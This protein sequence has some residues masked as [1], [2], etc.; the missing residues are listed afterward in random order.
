[1][2]CHP[3]RISYSIDRM[4]LVNDLFD[5]ILDKFKKPGDTYEDIRRAFFNLNSQ[6]AGASFNNF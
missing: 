3:I 4:E 2:I 6:Y 5:N 1:M